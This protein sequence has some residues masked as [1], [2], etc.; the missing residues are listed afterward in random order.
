MSVCAYSVNTNVRMR[1]LL[2]ISIFLIYI[3]S[4]KNLYI[5]V[6]DLMDD[7]ANTKIPYHLRLQYLNSADGNHDF[8]T[9]QEL[10]LD[11]AVSGSG[12]ISEV[13]EVD[14]F[15]FTPSIDSV[16]AIHINQHV[17]Q[18]GTQVSSGCFALRQCRQPHSARSCPG[19]NHFVI[20][21]RGS[22]PPIF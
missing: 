13:G 11:E 6:R 16:Q 14:C 15:T 9:A 12:E 4:P 21:D 3:D 2:P 7:D 22:C 17:P 8:A 19:A 20:P 18:D 1:R 5:N 10:S